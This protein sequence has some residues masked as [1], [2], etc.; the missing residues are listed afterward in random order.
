MML[1][2]LIKYQNSN[3]K[4]ILTKSNLVTD[5]QRE[6]CPYSLSYSTFLFIIYHIAVYL[7]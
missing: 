3:T 2:F 1:K 5:A 6:K 4:T 7:I